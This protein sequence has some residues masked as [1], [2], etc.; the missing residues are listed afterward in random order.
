MDNLPNNVWF[1]K[2][3]SNDLGQETNWPEHEKITVGV[4]AKY[5]FNDTPVFGCVS[6]I[7]QSAD[8]VEEDLEDFRDLWGGQTIQ[9]TANGARRLALLLLR[10]ADEA[11]ARQENSN[12]H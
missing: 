4:H 3:I 5:T 11:D 1:Q 9:T 7:Q 8:D 2:T 12:G 10:A 6:I